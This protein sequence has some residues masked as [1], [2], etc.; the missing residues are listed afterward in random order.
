MS[1]EEPRRK[2][3]KVIFDEPDELDSEDEQEYITYHPNEFD[4]KFDDLYAELEPGLSQGEMVVFG[5]K[6]LT[7][8]LEAV[9]GL[10]D[11]FKEYRYSNHTVNSMELK[12]TPIL[13]SIYHHIQQ[14]Y[15]PFI[16]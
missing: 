15:P 4:I 13:S 3:R 7:P 9:V 11:D 12:N 14:K 10:C 1:S 6:C 2:R 5:K 16:V 8:R